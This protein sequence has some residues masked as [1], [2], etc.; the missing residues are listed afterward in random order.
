MRPMNI[1]KNNIIDCVYLPYS[2]P[3]IT[4]GDP[5]EREARSDFQQT[6]NESLFPIYIETVAIYAG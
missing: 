5:Y 6:K 1:N 2:G 4:L 3:L